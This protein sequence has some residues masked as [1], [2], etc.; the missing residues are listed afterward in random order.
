VLLGYLFWTKSFFSWSAGL[1][2]ASALIGVAR[3]TSIRFAHF[4]LTFLAVQCSLNALNAI[5][6]LYFVSLRSSCGNDAAAMA[7]LTG[8]PAWIWA[9]LWA[10]LSIF[11]L[12]ISAAFYA[13]KSLRTSP[14]PV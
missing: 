7:S 3:F 11:I 13:R 14:F 4:F 2:T 9:M 5:K 12:T 8:L 6:N 10:V 1:L